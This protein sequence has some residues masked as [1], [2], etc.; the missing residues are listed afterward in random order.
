[1]E[2][3]PEMPRSPEQILAGKKEKLKNAVNLMLDWQRSEKIEKALLSQLDNLTS[4]EMDYCLEQVQYLDN[5]VQLR[6]PLFSAASKALIENEAK[7]KEME[8]IIGLDRAK[9]LKSLIE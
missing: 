8:E 7:L 2:K 5:Q 1:M 6:G 3:Q 4:E 9:E